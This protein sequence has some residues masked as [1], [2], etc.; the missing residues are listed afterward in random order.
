V[1]LVA[2]SAL[3]VYLVV[4]V[5]GPY[6]LRTDP[7]ATTPDAFAPLGSTGHPLG[8]DDL[9]RDELARLVYGGR[10]LLLV[11][12]GG[13]LLAGVAGTALGMV[14][15][16]RGGFADAVVMRLMDTILAFPLMLLA[17]LTLAVLD[18][19][20]L[21][22]ALAVGLS[23]IPY[24]ARLARNLT[25]RERNRDYVRSARALGFS[26]A[27]I[28]GRDIGPNLAG[29]LIVQATSI[30][31]VSAGIASA[32]SYLGLAQAPSVPDWGYMV[33]AGQEFFYDNPALAVLPG[34]LITGF[35]VACNF[36]GDDLRDALAPG[37]AP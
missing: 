36:A 27:R 13:V 5:V 25:L 34:L 9:G 22:A 10:P 37:S 3:V 19:G 16:Y 20:A 32:L 23:Q 24:F 8:T 7:T 29:P 21:N 26:G 18:R 33:K 12:L 4:V 1:A 17:I 2:W 15:G 6:L 35:V 30:T 28:L 14:A 31:A 11:T